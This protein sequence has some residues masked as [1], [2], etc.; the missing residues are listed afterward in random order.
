VDEEERHLRVLREYR[1]RGFSGDE[2]ETVYWTRQ[3]DETPVILATSRLAAQRISLNLA[4]PPSH[5]ADRIEGQR[6]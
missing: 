3:R 2:A 4:T 5:E 6:L 1:L